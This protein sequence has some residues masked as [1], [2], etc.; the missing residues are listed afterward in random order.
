MTAK[1]WV[2]APEVEQVDEEPLP[3][4]VVE[5][6]CDWC[7]AFLPVDGLCRCDGSL[8]DLDEQ[9]RRLSS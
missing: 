3:D 4:V 9:R 1:P 5:Y 8:R 6:R 7:W 2:P